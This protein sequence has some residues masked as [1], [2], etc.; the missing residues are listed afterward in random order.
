MK[1]E[2]WII[3]ELEEEQRRREQE[4]AQRNR[5][6]LPLAPSEG[7]APVEERGRGAPT[8]RVVVLDISPGD[9]DNVVPV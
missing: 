5:I 9:D 3:D 1:P 7:A 6:E 8:A 2:P 4:D